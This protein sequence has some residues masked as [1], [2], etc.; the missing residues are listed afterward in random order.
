MKGKKRQKSI[1]LAL[2]ALLITMSFPGLHG[3]KHQK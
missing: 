1:A 2:V 3:G